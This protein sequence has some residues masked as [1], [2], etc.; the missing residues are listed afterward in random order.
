MLIRIVADDE[1]EPVFREREPREAKPSQQ[2]RD[3]NAHER[4]R[5]HAHAKA[6]C[7]P[8]ARAAGSQ[9]VGAPGAGLSNR[10]P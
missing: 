1:R 8:Q 6:S 2:H 3:P 5:L 10:S 4:L 7:T 9:R